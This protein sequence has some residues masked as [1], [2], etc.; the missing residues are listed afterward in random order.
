MTVRPEDLATLC[1][2]LRAS[3]VPVTATHELRLQTV[4]RTLGAMPAARI[5][6]IVGPVVLQSREQVEALDEVLARW[7]PTLVP[8]EARPAVPTAPASTT[9][10]HQRQVE[11]HPLPTTAAGRG[12]LAIGAALL[13]AAALLAVLVVVPFD[14]GVA[15]D[16]GPRDAAP[17]AAPDAAP[18][19][20]GAERTPTYRPT[21]T[22]AVPDFQVE[23]PSR[24]DRWP[25][26]LLV[27][28][29]VAAGLAWRRRSRKRGLPAELPAPAGPG[30]VA[31]PPRLAPAEDLTRLTDAS[32]RSALVW[33]VDHFLA[34]SPR[35]RIDLGESVRATAR[36]GSRPVVVFA[37]ERQARAIWLWIDADAE[38]DACEQLATELAGTLR[39][40]GLAVHLAWF[41]GVPDR[42]Y[43]PGND[44][45]APDDLDTPPQEAVVALL[46]DGHALTRIDGGV[47]AV[48]LSGLRAWPR[49][50]VVD[51]ARGATDLPLRLRRYGLEV[52]EP[53]ALARWLGGEAPPGAAGEVDL[54][55]WLA[56][57]ALSPTP[58][59]P[60]DALALASQLGLPHPARY[61]PIIEADARHVGARLSWPWPTRAA[62]LAWL[63]RQEDLF[64]L[65]QAFWR[66]RHLP[67]AA[68]TAVDR[69]RAVEQAWLDLFTDPDAAAP[70][71]YAE[72]SRRAWIEEALAGLDVA[73]APPRPGAL[74]LGWTWADVQPM[75]RT[76]L[77]ARGFGG[78]VVEPPPPRRAR[79]ALLAC[80][81]VALSGV[82][83]FARPLQSG[84]PTILEE[85]ARPVWADDPV[86]EARDDGT[87]RVEFALRQHRQPSIDVPP[88]SVL[89]VDWTSDRARC[90]EEDGELERWYCADAD[91]VDASAE[92]GERHVILPVAADDADAATLA[93]ALLQTGNADE[94]IFAPTR[95][96]SGYHGGTPEYELA[97]LQRSYWLIDPAAYPDDPVRFAVEVRGQTY[98]TLAGRLGGEWRPAADV[99]SG[100]YGRNVAKQKLKGSD[101][102]HLRYVGATVE[103]DGG[104]VVRLAGGQGAPAVVAQGVERARAYVVLAGV[105]IARDEPGWPFVLPEGQGFDSVDAT[106]DPR[107][108][109]LEV[110]LTEAPAG[111]YGAVTV[112]RALRG[113]RSAPADGD[114]VVRFP[115]PRVPRPYEVG[116]VRGDCPAGKRL[117]TADEAHAHLDLLCPEVALYKGNLAGG[118]QLVRTSKGCVVQRA[119]KPGPWSLC[120]AGAAAQ[121]QKIPDGPQG[122]RLDLE[123]TTGDDLAS[124]T[125]LPVADPGGVR[126]TQV[127]LSPRGVAWFVIAG[128][129]AGPGWRSDDK[130]AAAWT[131]AGGDVRLEVT[132]NAPPP[133]RLLGWIRP[134]IAE[135]QV[136]IDVLGGTLAKALVD[137]YERAGDRMKA[138]AKTVEGQGR[139]VNQP[140][141][142]REI[143]QVQ[144]TLADVLTRASA[145]RSLSIERLGPVVAAVDPF[146]VERCFEDLQA[147]RAAKELLEKLRAEARQTL[148]VAASARTYAAMACAGG[149][150]IKLLALLDNVE[151]DILRGRY[152]AK[153]DYAT[154]DEAQTLRNEAAACVAAKAQPR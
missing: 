54:A 61:L 60:A 128:L 127:G 47:A 89:R 113:D 84:A 48:A 42:L 63:A 95:P 34:E 1:R 69:A 80:A 118:S 104:L 18:P 7:I 111:P 93:Q 29:G 30:A 97:L 88:G 139:R 110:G 27:L 117:V 103:P 28:A 58:V 137:A 21:G 116:V 77:L 153:Y 32:D 90:R 150:N 51:F 119:P 71:L 68:D 41:A 65:A 83:G 4:F 109:R 13:V 106:D 22:F 25:W 44:G 124:A 38:T 50:A 138:R 76:L 9:G 14:G 100:V 62:R 64:A 73:D 35:Q 16:A 82:I 102:P 131:T 70:L 15:P 99:W 59:D 23:P 141:V 6:R 96:Q 86:V 66:L 11:A 45:L 151:A 56:A 36:A 143:Q 152:G 72:P 37:Q 123:V 39:A 135:D 98:A 2:L 101:T 136:S 26:L 87:Y 154:L 3:G 24:A 5:P 122:A 85:G 132:L 140:C 126:I 55:P 40:S 12:R 74:R 120:A 115:P 17:E 31:P 67:G 148:Q 46:T 33:G 94:V 105:R 121:Q 142:E 149:A 114:L 43:L 130:A 91:P 144:A 112:L 146:G 52:I 78:E 108:G 134:H 57:L 20:A 129:G 53:E 75:T 145:T 147:S 125:F 133:A 92:R 10:Q 81:A 79:V 49:L 19:T 8:R 107:G